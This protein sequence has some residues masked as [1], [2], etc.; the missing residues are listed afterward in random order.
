MTVDRYSSGFPF[1]IRQN[2]SGELFCTVNAIIPAAHDDD[3]FC[4][5]IAQFLDPFPNI[6]GRR[7]IVCGKP[8]DKVSRVE[9]ITDRQYT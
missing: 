3:G 4:Q 1:Y 9:H 6:Q 2:V 7:S 8:V 5:W